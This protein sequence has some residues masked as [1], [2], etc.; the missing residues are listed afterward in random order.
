LG[1]RGVYFRFGDN[2][3]KVV[4]Q[5]V[6]YERIVV[7]SH[8]GAAGGIVVRLGSAVIIMFLRDEVWGVVQKIDERC[9]TGLL[10]AVFLFPLFNWSV[11]S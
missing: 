2:G 11:R 8:T 10:L 7:A 3:S 5:V 6:S 9:L 4:F 1:L